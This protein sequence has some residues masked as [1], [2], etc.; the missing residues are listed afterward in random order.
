[1]T[2]CSDAMAGRR[3]SPPGDTTAYPWQQVT[4]LPPMHSPEP[5]PDAQL[6]IYHLLMHINAV[7][8]LLIN[9]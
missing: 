6:N 9:N 3:A 5:A 8:H 4:Q 1:M 2:T 7:N